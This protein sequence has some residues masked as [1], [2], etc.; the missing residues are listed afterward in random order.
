MVL[1]GQILLFFCFAIIL[2]LKHL[3]SWSGVDF[4]SW[5]PF[6]CTG[7]WSSC[8]YICIFFCRVF[9]SI[10][11]YHRVSNPVPCALQEQPCRL[12]IPYLM[13]LLCNISSDWNIEF[14]H[15]LQRKQALITVPI[16]RVWA[17]ASWVNSDVLCAAL[18]SRV[19]ADIDWR[20][21]RPLN[22]KRPAL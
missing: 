4:Q 5:V 8:T 10:R 18:S 7:R 3:S 2:F 6:C 22:R 21:S 13:V 19:G 14:G 20:Y 16:Q 11:V 9:F 1:Q 17:P 12:S 15:W